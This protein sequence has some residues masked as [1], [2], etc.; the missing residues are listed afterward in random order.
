MANEDQSSSQ[1]G[2]ALSIA[3]STAEEVG[4]HFVDGGGFVDPRLP[5]GTAWVY[6]ISGTA[7][8]LKWTLKIRPDW[9]TEE[10][11]T[12]VLIFDTSQ[13]ELFKA[14]LEAMMRMNRWTPWIESPSVGRNRQ[15]K[16]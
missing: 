9:G 8:D 3:T 14:T 12:K 5:K 4:L 7:L 10:D 15:K 13:V 2:L 16:P 6:E 11:V 1:A